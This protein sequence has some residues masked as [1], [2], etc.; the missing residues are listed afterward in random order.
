MLISDY[1]SSNII[2]CIFFD[3]THFRELGQK[4][5]NIQIVFGSNENF[6]ICFRNLLT[7]ITL[8]L[9]LSNNHQNLIMMNRKDFIR[10]LLM[11]TLPLHGGSINRY[12]EGM[13]IQHLQARY[14]PI[15][16]PTQKYGMSNLLIKLCKHLGV[17]SWSSKCL[18]Q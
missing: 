1:L 14:S 13:I 12:L 16:T 18:L 17:L 8:Q 4:Q 2:I 7:F 11:C 15:S 6:K 10:R 9:I 3:L 5:K